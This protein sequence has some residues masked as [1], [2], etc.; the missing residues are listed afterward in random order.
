MQQNGCEEGFGVDLEA[1]KATLLQAIRVQHALS[2]D[3]MALVVAV[4][5][6]RK[7]AV[8]D[9]VINPDGTVAVVCQCGQRLA[10]E[11]HLVHS[12][13]KTESAVD[14]L[15][16]GAEP[17]QDAAFMLEPTTQ[18]DTTRTAEGH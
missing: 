7:H 18:V 2:R 14:F 12:T 5:I 8:I 9:G 10:P 11:R 6:G 3:V 4:E 13:A 17:C 15:A 1:I 16:S